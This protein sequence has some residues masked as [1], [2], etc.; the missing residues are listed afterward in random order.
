MIFYCFFVKLQMSI[1]EIA[2]FVSKE[3][4]IIHDILVAEKIIVGK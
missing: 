1:D 3:P 2:D 4:K